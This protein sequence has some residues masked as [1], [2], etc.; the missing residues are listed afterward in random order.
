[1]VRRLKPER[2]VHIKMDRTLEGVEEA[3]SFKDTGDL[4]PPP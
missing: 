2:E 1:M 4:L 3:Y